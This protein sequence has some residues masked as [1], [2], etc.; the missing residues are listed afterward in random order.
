V[1]ETQRFT[2]AEITDHRQNFFRYVTELSSLQAEGEPISS[3]KLP[4]AD[5]CPPQKYSMINSPQ[6][7]QRPQSHLSKAPRGRTARGAFTL[8]IP[9]LG[10]KGWVSLVE[11]VRGALFT[12]ASLGWTAV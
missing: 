3:T 4:L 6:R 7:A 5:F 2:N 9:L 11:H 1:A 12:A 8:A 10:A